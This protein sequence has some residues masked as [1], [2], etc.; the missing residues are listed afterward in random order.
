M[1]RPVSLLALFATIV[2]TFAFGTT[3]QLRKGFHTVAI[4]T[5]AGAIKSH[6]DFTNSPTSALRRQFSKLI[7]RWQSCVAGSE[8]IFYILWRP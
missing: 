6:L 7:D 8:N 3:E 2:G 4:G 5:A 1:G